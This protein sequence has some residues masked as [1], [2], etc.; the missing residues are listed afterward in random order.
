MIGFQFKLLIW[1]LGFNYSVANQGD[2]KVGKCLDCHDDK[3]KQA[4]VHPVAEG[5]DNCHVAT[6]KE[7]PG[8]DKGFT[9]SQKLPDL[10]ITCHPDA[11]DATKSPFSHKALTEKKSCVNCHSP[12]ST[13]EKKLLL[14]DEKTLC[15]SCH[16][17]SITSGTK[18]YSNIKLIVE[19]SKY[20]HAAIESGCISCHT[21]HGSKTAQLLKNNFPEGNYADSKKD[22]YSICFSCHEPGL[23][24]LEKST[25]ATSFRNG[26]KNLHFIH[27]K[28]PKG[29]SCNLCHNMHGS[30]NEHLIDDFVNFGNY[31]LPINYKPESTGGSCAPGCHSEKKYVR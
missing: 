23:L 9:L 19:K 16:N 20:V 14:K 13:T 7:H 17:K 6:G 22:S 8:S 12:H 15:L 3:L 26:D 11:M 27:L 30:N 21:P 31:K 29:R 25:V 5:C 1:I 2:F 4:V 18:K 10:C 24:E 28:G